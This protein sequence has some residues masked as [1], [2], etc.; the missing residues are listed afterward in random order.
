MTFSQNERKAIFHL[1]ICVSTLN[2]ESPLPLPL[3]ALV[4]K[5]STLIR[6]PPQSFMSPPLS[7]TL[8]TSS[9][10]LFPSLRLH[11]QAPFFCLVASPLALCPHLHTLPW[12][13]VI[14]GEPHSP[15]SEERGN[16][17]SLSQMRKNTPLLK[18]ALK[19]FPEKYLTR[20]K[21]FMWEKQ[22][23]FVRITIFS[24][25]I[26]DLQDI[27]MSKVLGC[28]NFPLFEARIYYQLKQA[29]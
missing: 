15:S 28:L 16:L 26:L 13:S 18:F 22:N 23:K 1:P 19:I 3:F 8:V 9:T 6:K 14:V 27:S 25:P 12:P 2:S 5:L 29:F 24:F 20:K 17:Y 11:W 21:H 10:R 7:S 4:Y